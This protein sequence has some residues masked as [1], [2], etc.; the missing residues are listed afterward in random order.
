MRPRTVATTHISTEASASTAADHAGPG[1]SVIEDEQS[2]EAATQVLGKIKSFGYSADGSGDY[3]EYNHR[4]A[5]LKADLNQTLPNFVRHTPNDDM[6]RQEVEAAVRDYSAAG[7]WWKTIISNSSVLPN[8]DKD[9]RL[10]ALW[11]SANTH[12]KNAEKALGR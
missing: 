11:E 7:S 1:T 12:L 10:Q 6:F 8:A 9:E 2:E 3:Q 5:L 4:L